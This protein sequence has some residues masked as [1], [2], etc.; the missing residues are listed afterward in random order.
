M[1]WMTGDCEHVWDQNGGWAGSGA[2]K[3]YPPSTSDKYCGLGS[4]YDLND[5]NMKKIYISFLIKFGSHYGPSLPDNTKL[6]IANRKDT[7]FDKDMGRVMVVSK[8]TTK[9]GPRYATL[10]GCFNIECK[11]ETNWNWPDGTEDLRLGNSEYRDYDGQWFWITLHSNANKGNVKLR[12]VSED[13]NYDRVI[14]DEARRD[15]IG[16][17]WRYVDIIGGY[18]TA[19]E[20]HPDNWFVIDN[21]EISNE[22][23]QPPEGFLDGDTDDGDDTDECC[24]C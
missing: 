6:V 14:A 15:L 13:G 4:F 20:K 1:L 5:F 16:G 17:I 10:S 24:P 22:P 7:P 23:T 9:G 19:S 2:A 21:L 8:T 3:F 11:F 18:W 12:V